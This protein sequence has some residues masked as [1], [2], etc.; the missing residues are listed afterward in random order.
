M[1]KTLSIIIKVCVVFAIQFTFTGCDLL[2][3][4]DSSDDRSDRS[5]IYD[6]YRHGE[7]TCL[8]EGAEC[9]VARGD[10]D[11]ELN[12][13]TCSS[14]QTCMVNR[15]EDTCSLDQIDTGKLTDL[16]LYMPIQFTD[17]DLSPFKHKV[18]TTLR[19]RVDVTA[20][21]PNVS[22]TDFRQKKLITSFGGQSLSLPL[23]ISFKFIP[24][25]VNQKDTIINSSSFKIKQN[26]N[27]IEFLS[28]KDKKS[29]LSTGSD[30]KT[31]SCNHYAI[32][33]SK[34]YIT[35]YINGRKQQ[36]SNNLP[37]FNS[38]RKK[39]IVS[40]Y[41]GKVWDLRI[42]E[43][44]ISQNDIVKLSESCDDQ[45]SM[46]S[47]YDGY[48]KYLCGVYYCIWWPEGI[49]DSTTENLQYQLSGHDM[50]W[51]H[52]ILTTG[53]YNHGNLC[54]V[55]ANKKSRNL[56]LTEG[57]R[58]SWVNNYTF[59]KPWGNYVLHE[60]F[61][62]YQ[63]GAGGSHKFFVEGTAEWGGYSQRPG[64]EDNPLLGMYT[65]QPHYALYANQSS[66]I[67]EG[68]IDFAKG[69]HQ[70]GSGIFY[71]YLTEFVLND[72][73]I[74]DVFNHPDKNPS[75][76]LY[77][78]IKE[79]GYDMGEI[80]VDFTAR[81]TTWDWPR[82]GPGYEDAEKRTY[83][84]M[85]GVN[86]KSDNP[87]PDEE[88]DN[89]ITVSYNAKG[90]GN[91]WQGVP[92]RYMIGSW[93]FNAY[94]VSVDTT[95]NYTVGIMPS[96][97][98]P[99]YAEFKA[100]VVVYNE[101]TGK[102]T[103]HVLEVGNS[104]VKTTINVPAAGGDKLYLVV[105]CT[106]STVF[107]GW[108]TYDYNYMIKQQN[109][110][111]QAPIKVILMAGQSNM[112][113]NN[114]SIDSLQRLLCHA[115][116]FNLQG[117]NCGSTEIKSE[118][119]TDLFLN[120]VYQDYKNAVNNQPSSDITKSLGN[121]LCRAGKIIIQGQTCGN[122]NFDLGDR[123]F[124]TISEYYKKG[125]SYAY[126][127]DA[128]KQ[129][130]TAR[131]LVKINSEG[132]FTSNLLKERSDVNVLMFTGSHDSNGTLGLAERYGA[133]FPKFGA[134]P[135]NYGPELTF[136]HY[137][138]KEYSS[139]LILLKVVQGGTSLRV[140]WRSKGVQANSNNNYTS[141]ELKKDSLYDKLIEKAK[142]ITNKATVEQYFPHLKNKQVEIAGFVWFQGWNDGCN[143]TAAENYE[144]NFRNFI[145]DLKRDLNMP[146]LPIVVAQ[147]HHGEPNSL[148]QMAQQTIADETANMELAITDDFSGYY[149]FD[150]ASHLGIGRRMAVK[151]IP[152]LP[153]DNNTDRYY[154]ISAKHS[155]KYLDVYGSSSADGAK[156]IQWNYHGRDNQKFKLVDAGGG[157][158]NIIAKHS[159]KYLD[160][161][162]T[163]NG[164]ILHQWY[165]N[166][167]DN[168]KFKLVDA[169]EGYYNIIVKY[170]GKCLDV[171]G[172]SQNNGAYIVQW[173]CDGRDS[174]KFS[175]E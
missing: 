105:S 21:F 16:F 75:S 175:F 101:S 106:P 37:L 2:K 74:G 36:I 132:I 119:L 131:E 54:A 108:D 84:R 160:A 59:S 149:H 28:R 110:I 68:I 143:Q 89:K 69:G 61:H 137:M 52:N 18:T 4:M 50:T 80:F 49:T 91:S 152:L 38:I 112:E 128:F 170:S 116:K 154:T 34:N 150:T 88:V 72:W 171:S 35:T 65:L 15:C 117:E 169:E 104:G 43:T 109:D 140:E 7:R 14:G 151:M 157:Y 172:A 95:R 158:Y 39:L 111:V 60:N 10:N 163:G 102:R 67:Q 22:R 47:P 64:T 142:A 126:G 12:C 122:K 165:Q 53:M 51:E 25:T 55:I 44:D 11:T 20:D 86:N 113:G 41:S 121:F 120:K 148:L 103:Y 96:V 141:E 33:I 90:T 118:E 46:Q 115:G 23:T 77:K 6:S 174:Q 82:Y 146:D 13:G 114:T 130:T 56:Q 134:S 92:D 24:Q 100:R 153:E 48:E 83:N 145:S 17:T 156:I 123:L 98:N 147:S 162:G 3:L 63:G 129:M 94:E 81:I 29:I 1:N 173:T 76:A 135:T 70:Y 62:A 58:K 124:K 166:N 97:S 73:L 42:F 99:A 5:D 9:G 161:G 159:G 107:S 139:D 136:G 30:L 31:A 71:E 57:Y 168:Q 40:Q 45:M 138:G 87:L 144:V 26:N 27:S 66:P 78:I 93:A 85:V 167:R 79:T 125:T 127:Y 155:G 164:Q 32:V 19:P 8:S 133:L